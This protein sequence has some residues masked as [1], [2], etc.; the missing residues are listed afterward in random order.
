MFLIKKLCLPLCLFFV[1]TFSI[2]Q[3]Q[4]GTS[5]YIKS[6]DADYQ[7]SLNK[8]DEEILKRRGSR[9]KANGIVTIPVV[10]HVIHNGENV[11]D[12]FNIS[13]ESIDESLVHLND[14]F[15]ATNQYASTTSDSE[16]QFA[17]AVRD[18][19]G[20]PTSGINRF[21]ASQVSGYTVQGYSDLNSNTIEQ[22][23]GWSSSDYV[24]I[25]VVSDF[26]QRE[27]AGFANLPSFSAFKSNSI[28]DGVRI[29][30]GYLNTIAL[31]HEMGHLLGLYHT[32]NESETTDCPNNQ[33]CTIDGDK[34]CDTD[35]HF[36]E[37]SCGSLS[38]T[39][40]NEC[41][42]Q[43]YGKVL[44]NFM[45]YG[46][47]S[48]KDIFTVG[49]KERMNLALEVSNRKYLLES[50]GGI[51]ATYPTAFFDISSR[52]QCVGNMNFTDK[53]IDGP[54]SWDWVFEGGTP[55]T[56]TE[57]N[58]VVSF[59]TPGVFDV[60]LSVSNS[61]GQNFLLKEDVITIHQEVVGSSCSPISLS[62]DNDFVVGIREFHFKEISS[63]TGQ[64]KND[65]NATPGGILDN[66][67]T[68]IA[69]V[70]SGEVVDFSILVG[71]LNSENVNMYVDWNND[72]ILNEQE[73]KVV[74]LSVVNGLQELSF[75]VPEVIEDYNTVIRMRIIDDFSWNSLTACSSL[76]AGQSEDYGLIIAPQQ[77]A[78]VANFVANKTVSCP[79]DVMFRNTSSGSPTSWLWQ[80]EGGMPLE[81]T[82][83]NPMVSYSTAG[84]YEV[85]LTSSNEFGE[86]IK[87]VTHYITIIENELTGVCNPSGTYP[88][89]YY[90][91]LGVGI[92]D[93]WFESGVTNDDNIDRLLVGYSDHT[94]EN[95]FVVDAT[96]E[97][98]VVKL[99]SDILFA[100]N[101]YV[102]I[103][104]N[105]DGVFDTDEQVFSTNTK[106]I[107]EFIYDISSLPIDQLLRMRF[108]VSPFANSNACFDSYETEDYGFIR[109][110]QSSQ[111]T[112]F[113]D[114]AVAGVEALETVSI[115]AIYPNPSIGVFQIRSGQIPEKIE[116]INT[117]GQ[118]IEMID[119]P[120]EKIDLSHLINGVYF[121][122]LVWEGDNE[123][124][125]VI[126]NK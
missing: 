68:S 89:D 61:L 6:L 41:S 23:T 50:K 35:P 56:S 114:D 95:S 77:I 64:T 67:C 108:I 83:L 125:S 124:Q 16:I 93:V 31:V 104:G 75:R 34:V 103:D 49:Q 9:K 33:D 80:F 32:F 60:S 121:I 14:A 37:A 59:S 100:S 79:G 54:T 72:G 63:L 74:A 46:S 109:Q 40:N 101:Y 43:P 20:Q 110:D 96:K 51:A 8:L 120:S 17:L 25:W 92:D 26:Y 22:A 116:V 84:S 55:S 7:K 90:G 112:T 36:K 82:D 48:C 115:A 94:C 2:A 117:L 73:E 4:C 53:S 78:P 47:Y 58:P 70:I 42:N 85:S 113:S 106:G 71:T 39:S 45:A 111:V 86:S 107:Y 69:H 28:F 87:T 27:I 12:G 76:E 38:E 81:S 30:S 15:R 98:V 52:E 119:Q 21:N 65:N 13:V 102:Y 126:I 10:I 62:P 11:G 105:N 1:H 44:R 88:S 123:I 99:T 19:N 18:P 66:T 118:T 5:D 24:N 57:R 29:E 97:R 91:V 122:K 3:F